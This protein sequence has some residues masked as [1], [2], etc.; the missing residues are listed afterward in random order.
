MSEKLNWID[1][2]NEQALWISYE[3][4]VNWFAEMLGRSPTLSQNAVE[5]F[6]NSL[7]LI[8]KQVSAIH[9]HEQV[10]AHLIDEQLQGVR[11]ELVE[12]LENESGTPFSSRMP[13]MRAR[14]RDNNDDSLLR[15]LK[16][17]LILQFAAFAG[18]ALDRKAENA[19]A[20][21]EGI[22]REGT[23]TH[24]S[25]VPSFPAEIELRWRREIPILSESG[26]ELSPE[27]LRCAD[28]FLARGKG[29]FCSDECRFRTFQLTKQLA[30]PGYLAAKQR[31]YRQRQD[32]RP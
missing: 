3:D 24:L 7:N 21:C 23:A 14:A 4:L 18:E 17:T 29:R 32:K 5:E 20:R 22:Y 19:V 30:D 28:F 1:I 26:L 27:I 15:S 25:P 13:A 8:R 11:L 12:S 6:Q 9:F 31:R 2:L 16:E 10:D